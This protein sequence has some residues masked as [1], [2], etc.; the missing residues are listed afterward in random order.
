LPSTKAGGKVCG[1]GDFSGSS[2]F[3]DVTHPT[4]DSMTGSLTVMGWI[5]VNDLSNYQYVY[6]N[7]RDCCGPT[8]G[9]QLAGRYGGSSPQFDL[10]FS[11]GT[12][13]TVTGGAQLTAGSWAHLVGSW[14]GTT[15][16]LYV[17]GSLVA[18]DA[19]FAG[20]SYVGTSSYPGTLGSMA[21][22]QGAYGANASLDEVKVWNR[23]LTGTEISTIYGYENMGK[24]WN[25]TTPVCAAPAALLAQYHFEES[26]AWNG[27]TGEV[28][29]TAGANGGPYNGTLA[30]SPAATQLTTSP[31]LTGTPGT[32]A[33]AKLPGPISNGGRIELR[34]L[35]VSTKAGDQTSVAFWMYWDGTNGAM[36]IGW[37]VYDLWMAGGVFGFNTGASDVYGVSNAGLANGWHHVVAVFYNG[38]VF[39]NLIYI[40]GV[41]QPMP[42][43]K[44]SPNLSNAYAQS[45]LNVGGVST[46]SYYRFSGFVDEV[47]VYSGTLYPAQVKAIY[48]QT[49]PCL[50]INVPGYLNAFDSS[51]TPGAITGSIKTK[52][53]GTAYTID[54]VAL[55]SGKTAVDTTY[56]QVIKVEVL[57][58]VSAG[59]SLDSSNCP[60]TYTV[61]QTT[62]ATLASGRVTVP[63]PGE[64]DV[65]RDARI[66][67]SYPATGTPSLVACST[68]NFAIRP[69]SL[70][71]LAQDADWQTGGFARTLNA[72]T[73]TAT[74]VHKA[75]QPFGLVVSGYN[76]LG[77]LTSNYNGSPTVAS[78]TCSLPATGCVGGSF[79]QGTFSGSGGTVNSTT[80]AYSEVGVISL[81]MQD[82]SFAGVDTSD[83]SLTADLTAYSNVVAVGR[84]VPDHFVVIPGT[85]TQGCAVPGKTAY[86]YLGQDSLSTRQTLFAQNALN[87]T[88]QNYVGSLARLNLASYASYGFSATGMPVGASLGSGSQAPLGTWLAGVATDTLTNHV[89]SKLV[90][91]A[92]PASISILATPLDSDGVTVAAPVTVASNQLYRHG[93]L[94]LGNAY[95]AT[96]T[97]LVLPMTAQYWSGS[98]YLVNAD[99]GCTTLTSSALGFRNYSAD[100]STAEMGTSHLVGSSWTLTQGASSLRLSR[101]SGGDGKYRG[102]ADLF[103]NLGAD[104]ACTAAGTTSLLLAYLQDSWPW[105]GVNCA[106]PIAR[107]TFGL[108]KQKFMFRREIH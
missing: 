106:N 98:S 103:F 82:A 46:N 16:R 92:A 80:A 101:P 7:A 62:T 14:D 108:E 70:S 77:A 83:G 63:L 48:A 93:R 23:A 97:D 94:K 41:L 65:W 35:P 28:K 42:L 99:D 52:V 2:D 85:V 90:I 54:V 15:L 26:T 66:R 78:V 43:A 11:D 4:V 60:V 25:G 89:V 91:P 10:W 81:Q 37:F 17:N 61:L 3:V 87:A 72:T 13:A 20:K 59:T 6:S 74:P 57:G 50:P 88:T 18:S 29:D 31:P 58:N 105:M 51:T 96:S 71:V 39:N 22:T 19:S 95:G 69:A 8:H 32:C 27:T 67:M 75:G 73:A 100:L 34:N 53:A 79:A 49:H 36:P 104:A 64:P 84:F 56:K 68:D 102:S 5:N 47:Q 40:D 86:T 38:S 1:Q 44:T 9:M 30:G 12:H 76:S 107:A 24:R 21:Y 45:T 55:N 33:Y